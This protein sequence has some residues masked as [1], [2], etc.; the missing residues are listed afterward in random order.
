MKVPHTQ[1][2]QSTG[3]ECGGDLEKAQMLDCRLQLQ[4]EM[5]STQVAISQLEKDISRLHAEISQAGEAFKDTCVFIGGPLRREG[6]GMLV[7][8]GYLAYCIGR[9]E[10]CS[11][12]RRN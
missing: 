11:S 12:K 4:Q 8:H 7:G 3:S 10:E 9:R 5:N 2:R 1:A 6:M